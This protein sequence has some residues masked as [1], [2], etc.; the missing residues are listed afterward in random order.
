MK[1]SRGGNE[2]NDWISILFPA[3]GFP[4]FIH[5][6]SPVQGEDS[7]LHAKI[8]VTNMISF[9]NFLQLL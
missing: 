4:G 7:E 5:D 2:E 3:L 1:A 8:D 9:Y 6:S